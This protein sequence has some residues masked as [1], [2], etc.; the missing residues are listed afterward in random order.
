MYAKRGHFVPWKKGKAKDRLKLGDVRKVG[1][2]Q[3]SLG[4]AWELVTYM[5]Q[6]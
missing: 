5:Y 6:M 1:I 3:N 2:C 4:E